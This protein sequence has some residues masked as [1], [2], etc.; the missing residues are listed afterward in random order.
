LPIP[1]LLFDATNSPNAL[2]GIEQ[3]D[4]DLIV[5]RAVVMQQH[6]PVSAPFVKPVG[7]AGQR[8]VIAELRAQERGARGW[9]EHAHAV[10]RAVAQ[11]PPS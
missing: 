6:T 8:R 1:G 5:E 3:D 9:R 7:H 10:E 2:S 11:D 4:A